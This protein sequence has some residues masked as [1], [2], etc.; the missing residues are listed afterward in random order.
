MALLLLDLG[1][2]A[3]PDPAGDLIPALLEVQA[4]AV[5]FA[6]SLIGGGR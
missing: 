6:L 1:Y 4:Q 5:Q 2:D 3:S